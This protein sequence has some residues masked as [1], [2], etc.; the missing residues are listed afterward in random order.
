MTSTP[1]RRKYDTFLLSVIVFVWM[2]LFCKLTIEAIVD[3]DQ[4]LWEAD[5]GSF[6]FVVEDELSALWDM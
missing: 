2:K 6:M 5:P 3:G 4:V 1:T